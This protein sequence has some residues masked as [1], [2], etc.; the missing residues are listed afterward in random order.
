QLTEILPLI[1]VTASV[2]IAVGLTK[3]QVSDLHHSVL[4]WCCNDV[5]I[6]PLHCMSIL[7]QEF[8]FEFFPRCLVMQTQLFPDKAEEIGHCFA[9]SGISQPALDIAHEAILVILCNVTLDD[10]NHEHAGF[11]SFRRV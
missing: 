2:H 8:F 1:H 4:V 3:C 6:A 11:Y 9:T 7:L 10:P 5:S